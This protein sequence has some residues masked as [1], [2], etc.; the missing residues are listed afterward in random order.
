MPSSMVRSAPPENASLPEVMTTPL[1]AAS[2]V[3]ASTMAASSM[4]VVS[5]STFIDL[6]GI[7]H[8]TS[9]MPSASVST[10]KFL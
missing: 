2:L 1:I 6:P 9:A 8:V 10:L 3:V 4:L 5:S 7:S